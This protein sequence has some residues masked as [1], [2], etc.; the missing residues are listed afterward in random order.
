MLCTL[1]FAPG[2]L[3]KLRTLASRRTTAEDL[4]DEETQQGRETGRILLQWE[5]RAQGKSGCTGTLPGRND[6]KVVEQLY[7]QSMLPVLRREK[8]HSG[9]EAK[10]NRQ[11]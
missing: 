6:W 9:N 5:S 10:Q 2:H 7:W 1:E 8:S 11:P 3:P 4:K